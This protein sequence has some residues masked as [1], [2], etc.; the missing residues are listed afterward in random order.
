M[1]KR[2]I[3]TQRPASSQAQLSPHHSTLAQNKSVE[4]S[5]NLWKRVGVT[6]IPCRTASQCTMRDARCPPPRRAA[7]VYMYP[8]RLK[9]PTTSLPA[10]GPA[11][12]STCGCTSYSSRARERRSGGGAVYHIPGP[13]VP[14]ADTIRYTTRTMAASTRISPQQRAS[15]RISPRCAIPI[16][17]P[18]RDSHMGA[19]SVCMSVASKERWGGVASKGEKRKGDEGEMGTVGTRGACVARVTDGSV[20]TDDEGR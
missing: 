14:G 4:P 15:H 1:C 13:P 12:A 20:E 11:C 18:I 8:A 3:L 7:Y 9:Q 19:A 10:H 16:P 2:T 17:I 6:Y 5:V